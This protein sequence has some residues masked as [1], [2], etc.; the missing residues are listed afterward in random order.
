[1]RYHCPRVLVSSVFS[2]LPCALCTDDVHPCAP[3]IHLQGLDMRSQRLNPRSPCVY[4]SQSGLQHL[5]ARLCNR[6]GGRAYEGSGSAQGDKVRHQYHCECADRANSSSLRSLQAYALTR[7]KLTNFSSVST[8]HLRPRASSAP[9]YP[10][11][12]FIVSIHS[13]H[14]C[15]HP[16]QVF[17]IRARGYGIDQVAED[18]GA[19]SSAWGSK[20]CLRSPCD[21]IDQAKSLSPGACVRFM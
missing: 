16:S 13:L 7:I 21:R 19:S 11:L 3:T 8:L 15:L 17:G 18:V 10:S 4:S 12:R 1:M 6:S 20:V 14:T 5:S 2:S 9:P